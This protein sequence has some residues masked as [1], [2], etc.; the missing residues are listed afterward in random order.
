[1]QTARS[2]AFADA[3]ARAS[4]YATLAGRSLGRVET[5]SETVDNG[6]GPI[7]DKTV[8]A[9]AGSAPVPIS[10]GQQQVT[11]S[12]TVTFQMT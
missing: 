4:Q 3:K 9:S 8:A 1:M 7:F 5:I 6:G 2:N 12:V 11:I 10:P